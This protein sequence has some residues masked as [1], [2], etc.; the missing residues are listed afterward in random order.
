MELVF[1]ALGKIVPAHDGN[2]RG[3]VTDTT[4]LQLSI[5]TLGLRAPLEVKPVDEHGFYEL[6]QGHRR[7]A[8]LKALFN[9]GTEVP[10][11]T[12]EAVP[13]VVNES[14]QEIDT[15]R[16]IQ[17]A[18]NLAEPLP[19]SKIGAALYEVVRNN[20]WPIERAARACG[21]TVPMAELLVRLATEAPES[22]RQKIDK[23][24]LSLS[25]YKRI[26]NTTVDI[27]ETVADID[28]HVTIERAV[29]TS[30]RKR[31]DDNQ[32]EEALISNDFVERLNQVKHE[33]EQI[34]LM[35]TLSR[36]EKF[37]LLE[38]QATIGRYILG[39]GE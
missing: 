4:D 1:V 2:V 29:N 27:Q 15:E 14:D 35:P 28:G 38:I 6:R 26:M 10:N 25:A 20:Q 8:A 9:A 23:G 24:E 3:G 30:R 19:P 12:Y 17:I 22:L 31:N 5:R 36:R 11:I 18:G 37:A 33:L 21:Y 7:L 32:A 16:L 39:E 34:C 13:C